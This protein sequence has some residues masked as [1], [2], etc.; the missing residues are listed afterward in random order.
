MGVGFPVTI[1]VKFSKEVFSIGYQFEQLILGLSEKIKVVVLDVHGLL[2]G[3][4]H[5]IMCSTHSSL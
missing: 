1:Y 3:I 4:V 5:W 2:H